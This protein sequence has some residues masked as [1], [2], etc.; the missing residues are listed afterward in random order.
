[1]LFSSGAE[2]F[3]GD[4]NGHAAQIRTAQLT[5]EMAQA[6]YRRE[7]ETIDHL[8]AQGAKFTPEMLHAAVGFR[9]HHLTDKCLR[10]GV[11]PDEDMVKT[12]VNHKDA[13]LTSMLIQRITPTPQLKKYI[14]D[15]ATD[16]VKKAAAP[17]LQRTALE[18]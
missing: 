7:P 3:R 13:P 6:F 16:A 10:A 8:A 4:F 1:M 2:S 14:E 12:A 15:Y 5:E 9:D 17:A 11:T 18:L